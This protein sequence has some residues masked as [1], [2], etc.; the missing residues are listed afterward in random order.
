M[1]KKR[2]IIIGIVIPCF[3]GILVAWAPDNNNFVG[4]FAQTAWAHGKSLPYQAQINKLK[5]IELNLKVC[6]KQ[7]DDVLSLPPDLNTPARPLKSALNKLYAIANKLG[8]LEDRVSDVTDEIAIGHLSDDS[9]P[10]TPAVNALD[11]VRS[12]AEIIGEA[13]DEFIEATPADILPPEFRDALMSIQ[14]RVQLNISL[15]QLTFKRYIPIRFVQFVN[16]DSQILSDER[17]EY[18]IGLTNS[19]FWPARIRFFM[20]T[21]VIV[22]NSEFTFLYLRD[23][24]GKL[25]LDEK[26]R[27]QHVDYTWPE[28]LWESP[29]IW[30]LWPDLAA[31]DDFVR[32]EGGTES[33]YYAQMRAG[34]YMCTDDEILVYINRGR[35]N[36]GQYPWYSRIIG[37]TSGHMARPGWL[38]NRFTFAHEVGHYLGLP[39][40]FPDHNPYDPDY[41]LAR[42]ID[43]PYEG[44]PLPDQKR[45]YGTHANLVNPETNATSELSLFWDHVFKPGCNATPNLFFNSR[46]EA[47]QYEADLQPIQQWSNGRICLPFDSW[48]EDVYAPFTR[49]ELTVA[50]GCRGY[51]WDFT[52]CSYNDCDCPVDVLYTGDPRV[53]T[54]SKFGSTPDTIQL[55]VM[56]YGYPMADGSDSPRDILDGVFLLRVTVDGVFLSESQLEQIDRVLTYDADTTKY[57]PGWTGKR[58]KLGDCTYC[59]SQ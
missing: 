29:L 27:R 17:L 38:A 3:L 37:M 33:R 55:N 48:C 58:P 21:N 36:G 5:S 13:I 22:R 54:F 12:R 41:D 20:R 2:L 25:I 23:S 28:N 30:P 18:S 40:T 49:L 44:D 31:Y 19:I 7:L 43:P 4:G 8:V 35:S 32:P 14:E 50:S 6:E 16:S 47:A 52:D 46:E 59:H 15:T 34:T 26:G 45:V 10:M 51:A 1:K 57:F 9:V 24:D 39:H 42:M 56:S 11:R 53:A